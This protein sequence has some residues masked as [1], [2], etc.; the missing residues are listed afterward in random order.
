M[1]ASSIPKPEPIVKTDLLDPFK[2]AD[3]V[4]RRSSIAQIEPPVKNESE[5]VEEIVY[6]KK[7]IGVARDNYVLNN[8]SKKKEDSKEVL[9]DSLH[10][11]IISGNN[12]LKDGNVKDEEKVQKQMQDSEENLFKKPKQINLSKIDSNLKDEKDSLK[13]SYKAS[14]DDSDGSNLKNEVP[15]PNFKSNL[16]S[17]PKAK[18]EVKR[19]NEVVKPAENKQAN[20]PFT[21]QVAVKARNLFGSTTNQ[22]QNHLQSS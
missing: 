2:K 21:N 3:D 15:S 10:S 11:K 5:D 12:K 20:N 22:T 4:S 16:E 8:L 14:S 6:S 19:L 18:E 1:Q 13:T 9:S 17:K 7:R